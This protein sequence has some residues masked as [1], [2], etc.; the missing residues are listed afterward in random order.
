MS[1]PTPHSP[2]M[3]PP[4]VQASSGHEWYYCRSAWH[5]LSLWVRL[6]FGQMYPPPHHPYAHPHSQYRHL[7]AKSG[8]TSGQFDIWSAFGSGWPVYSRVPL[9]PAAMVIPVPW[10]DIKV[11]ADK[12]LICYCLQF[13][14]DCLQFSWVLPICNIPSLVFKSMSSV[15]WSSA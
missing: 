1:P 10:V 6:M 12:K 2:P 13:S 8:I 9:V 3:P 11:V 14:I 5:L 4:L 7:V 15:V